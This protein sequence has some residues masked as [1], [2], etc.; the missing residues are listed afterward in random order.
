MTHWISVEIPHCRVLFAVK[1]ALLSDWT[2]SLNINIKHNPTN[3]PWKQSS[4][5]CAHGA[6]SATLRKEIHCSPYPLV[7][8]RRQYGTRSGTSVYKPRGPLSPQ[9][10]SWHSRHRSQIS[11]ASCAK[12]L[13]SGQVLNR[14]WI[15]MPNAMVKPVNRG[16][17][18]GS[19]GWC[20]SWF[21][22]FS[23]LQGPYP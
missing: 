4:I 21:N 13:F 11:L 23:S 6:G 7:T 15:I 10:C 16:P 17:F 14:R 8:L 20:A 18:V 1:L 5:C 12:I 3:S 9:L 2:W 19:S 22:W